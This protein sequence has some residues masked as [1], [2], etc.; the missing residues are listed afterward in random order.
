M[1]SVSDNL[2]GA[3]THKLDPKNRIAIPTEWRPKEGCALLLLSGRRLELPTVK[4]YTKEKFLQLIDKIKSSPDYTEA[5]ID[6][7][8]GKL[9]ANCV[10]VVIN[11]QGKLLIPKS[12]CEHA[13]LISNVKLASRGG[14]FELWEPAA[15]K[16]ASLREDSNISDINK[17]FGIF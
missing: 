11:G 3:Y 12:M 9:Y 15:F 7:F 16:E 8:I 10:E 6:L 14:Y 5:Q 2:F 17:S 4:V 13:G 1:S